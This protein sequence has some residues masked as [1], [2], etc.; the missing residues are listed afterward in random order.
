MDMRDVITTLEN[1]ERFMAEWIHDQV[2]ARDNPDEQR[3][4]IELEDQ[5]REQANQLRRRLSELTD[6][7]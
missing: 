6:Y 4:L 1:S 2:L 7:D 3:L 5:F